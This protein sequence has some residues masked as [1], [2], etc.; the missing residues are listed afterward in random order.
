MTV[1]P[2][3]ETLI[4]QA[5]QVRRALEVSEDRVATLRNETVILMRRMHEAGVSWAEIARTFEC[6]PQAAMYA[7]GH[8]K[9]TP[10]KPKTD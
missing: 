9:R 2:E 5:V 4:A 8:A 1:N 6:T 7:T 3:H 10:R